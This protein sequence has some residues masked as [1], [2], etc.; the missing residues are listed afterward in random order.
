MEDATT[1]LFDLRGLRVVSCAQ[2]PDDRRAVTM[3][4]LTSTR[5]PVRYSPALSPMTCP[6]SR[7]R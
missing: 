7:V 5:A 3:R 2:T 1:L 4:S 6:R